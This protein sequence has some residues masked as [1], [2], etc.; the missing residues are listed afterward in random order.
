MSITYSIRD[1]TGTTKYAKAVS[2]DGSIVN[3][4]VFGSFF[5]I[6]WN[7]PVVASITSFLTTPVLGNSNRQGA[8]IINRGS[9]PVDMFY[10]TSGTFGTG[11]PLL[12][13]VERRIDHSNLYRGALS[14]VADVGFSSA[15][16]IFEAI[17]A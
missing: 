5:E 7:A 9:N 16:L 3:P 15:I 13:G 1:A 12:P 17:P 2:G 10:G 14:F 11:L 6:S 4:Y 8:I